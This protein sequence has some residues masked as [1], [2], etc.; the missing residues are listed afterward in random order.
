MFPGLT[1]KLSEESVASTTSI[2]PKSDLVIVTG[3][4]DIATIIP[5]FGGGFSGILYLVPVDGAVGLLTTGNIAAAV[6]MPQ[7]QVTTL[8]FSK[9]QQKWYPAIS[10]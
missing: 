5:S 8:T 4:T 10:G 9:S 1:T 6:S 3:S 7:N 2:S